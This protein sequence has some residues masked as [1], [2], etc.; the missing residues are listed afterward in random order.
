MLEQ[1]LMLYNWL[2]LS[3]KPQKADILIL[4]GSPN[5]SIAD[6]GFE[7]YKLGFAHYLVTAGLASMTEESGWGMPLANKYTEHLLKRGVPEQCIITQNKS[8][9]TLEDVTFTLPMLIENEVR[10][11]RVI[12]INRP[13][14]QRRS[15]ATFRKHSPI[16]ELMNVPCDAKHPKDMSNVELFDL[17]GKC[18]REYEKLITYAVKGDI[19]KQ[20]IPIEVEKAYQEL[21]VIMT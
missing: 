7:L 13:V 8:M 2:A 5:L 12:L 19:E 4:F 6:K 9:N 16:T 21:L 3:E 17:A 14:Y 20:P 10:F 11:N 18:I 15:W 1:V